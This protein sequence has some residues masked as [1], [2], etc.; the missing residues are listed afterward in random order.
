MDASNLPYGSDS[1]N[2][3]AASQTAPGYRAGVRTTAYSWELVRRLV[4]FAPNW[5]GD[6]VQALPAVADVR[7]SMHD[8]TITMAARRSIAPL[9]ELVSG[10][11]DVIV[12]NGP[13]GR[14]VEDL[15]A[16]RFDAALL[17]PNS[18]RA[19][20]AARRARIGER[21]G[22]RTECRGP[23]LT[24]AV[25]AQP[26]LHQAVYYQ[27][28][29]SALG[30][31]SGPLEPRLLVPAAA[32]ET[33]AALLARAGWDGRS[34]VVAIAPGAAYG[35]SKRWPT[36]SFADLATA[37]SRDG[38]AT[39]LV[40]SDRD[41][42]VGAELI[43]SVGAGARPLDLVGTDLAAMAGILVHCRALVSNDSGAMHFGAALGLP[44][45]GIFGPTDER[46]TRP[47]GDAH[48]IITN[49]VWCR[50]CW[51]RECPLDHRCMRGI[52]VATV[53]AAVR[54]SL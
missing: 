3:L 2:A 24:R 36:Q 51:L 50:P 34:P 43:A 9:F 38:V 21:W 37:L 30:I 42:P 18:F 35:G 49:P 10:V 41:R 27:H 11:D 6:T 22:Y 44:V 53:L 15:R 17:L 46:L 40:G 14:D 8:A 26:D 48:A 29:V 25:T 20:L 1:G 33:G 39:V 32:R 13:I 45:T 7:R 12:L 23:L 5:L 16:H 54:R 4:V 47:V 31:P 28:L 19:A 52:G